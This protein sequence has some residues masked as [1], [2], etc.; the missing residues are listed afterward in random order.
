MLLRAL[1][2]TAVVF[3]S[4]VVGAQEKE[5]L[6]TP[7]ANAVQAQS[8]V[9]H[10]GWGVLQDDGS[11]KGQVVTIGSGSSISPQ[12][13]ATIT[14]SKDLVVLATTRADADGSFV[15]TGLSPG[16]Y[17]IAAESPNCYGIVSFEAVPNG[18]NSQNASPPAMEV[19]AT[20]MR[21]TAVDE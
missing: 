10:S 18:Q 1:V 8:S 2:L 5:V 19:Y 7:T 13:N 6:P 4:G 15:L 9:Y 3:S 20:S 14:L 11:L 17:E 12:G 16:V 21:R